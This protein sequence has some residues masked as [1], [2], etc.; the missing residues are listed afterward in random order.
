[1]SNR[2]PLS[3]VLPESDT[4][5]FVPVVDMVCV[6]CHK[7]SFEEKRVRGVLC[8][9]CPSCACWIEVDEEEAAV[10]TPPSSSSSVSSI[11]SDPE[12][13]TESDS[14]SEAEEEYEGLCEDCG[15]EWPAITFHHLDGRSFALCVACWHQA[16]HEEEYL[17]HRPC[18]CGIPIHG[19]WGPEC[20]RCIRVIPYPA[21][22]QE[23]V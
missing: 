10:Q 15:A 6:L 11:A 14:E 3:L 21:D 2:S 17:S 22:E 23:Q 8:P 7:P 20:G 5:G 4:C 9:V 1:M 19:A 16:D 13:D 18:R 12:S